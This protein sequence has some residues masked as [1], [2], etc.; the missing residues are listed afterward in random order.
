M[1]ALYPVSVAAEDY[2]VGD[3]VKWFS[4]STDISPYVGR[5]VA[6]SPKICK[7]WVT[8]PIGET[9]QMAPEELILV[10]PTQGISVVPA[11]N[12]YDSVDKQMSAK[13]FGT[14][15]PVKRDVVTLKL[16]Q[17]FSK[18]V[19]MVSKK[20]TESKATEEFAKKASSK[21]ASMSSA[22]KL[23]GKTSMQSYASVFDAFGASVS[24]DAIRTIITN[25]YKA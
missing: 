17:D 1:P 18:F 2:K 3:N 6:I 20:A 9:Q 16:A 7:V 4:S 19:G 25:I 23:A 11:D 15:P 10:P 22:H 12:G 5:V 24:D 21:I 8:W 14:V 13:Y